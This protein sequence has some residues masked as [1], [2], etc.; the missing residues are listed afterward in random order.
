[1]SQLAKAT[2]IKLLST[3]NTYTSGAYFCTHTPE[4]LFS[5]RGFSRAYRYVHDSKTKYISAITGVTT[6]I[7]LVVVLER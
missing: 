5:G 2:S 1:M 3:K 7:R 6:A 4:V